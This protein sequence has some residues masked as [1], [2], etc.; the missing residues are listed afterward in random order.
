MELG[1]LAVALTRLQHLDG[2]M[3][4]KEG[5][6]GWKMQCDGLVLDGSLGMAGEYEGEEP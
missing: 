1:S 3:M 4:C 2:D 6:V 5:R